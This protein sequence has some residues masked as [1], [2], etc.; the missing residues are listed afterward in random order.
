[1]PG[2]IVDPGETPAEAVVRETLE[3]TGINIAP[4]DAQLVQTKTFYDERES[5]NITKYLFEIHINYTPDVTLSWEHSE[6][7]W[8]SRQEFKL[9]DFG[10]WQNEMIKGYFIDRL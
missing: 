2:G 1:M 5:K 7:R 10:T 3:E 8:I 6:Y 9:I 4:E